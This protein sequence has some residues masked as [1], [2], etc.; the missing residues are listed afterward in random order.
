MESIVAS[1]LVLAISSISASFGNIQPK[2]AATEIIQ[3]P[4]EIVAVNENINLIRPLNANCGSI[5]IPRGFLDYHNGIDY[6]PTDGINAENPCRIVAAADGEVIY[7]DWSNM[8]EGYMVIIKH[9]DTFTTEYFHGD[10]KFYVKAGDKFVG[11]QDIMNMGNTGNATGAHLHFS[12][13]RNGVN[14]DPLQF[15]Q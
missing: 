8:G 11:G 2:Q 1:V 6:V 9:N 14:V 13:K 12:L 4:Q 3:Q 7:A 5:V 15:M 10:G